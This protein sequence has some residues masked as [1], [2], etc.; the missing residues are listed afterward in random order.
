M[1]EQVASAACLLEMSASGLWPKD[2]AS[3]E[4]FAVTSDD[5]DGRLSESNALTELDTHDTK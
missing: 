2:I 4:H 5:L 1:Q 3:D